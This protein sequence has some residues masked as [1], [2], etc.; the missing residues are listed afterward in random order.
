MNVPLGPAPAQQMDC[1]DHR[2]NDV[3]K[4]ERNPRPHQGLV[5]ERFPLTKLS[6]YLPVPVSPNVRA[7]LT[8]PALG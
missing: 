6:P 7:V 5:E 2:R 4:N 1:E 8:P 3:K